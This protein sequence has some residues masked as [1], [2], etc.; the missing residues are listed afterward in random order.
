MPEWRRPNRVGATMNR[1]V[2]F[3]L[4]AALLM[5][6]LGWFFDRGAPAED[7]E[8]I[9]SHSAEEDRNESIDTGTEILAKAPEVDSSH[10][11]RTDIP[12]ADHDTLAQDF[13]TG[14]T[15]LLDLRIQGRTEEY[16]LAPPAADLELDVFYGV[17]SRDKFFSYEKLEHAKSVG[18]VVLDQQ[19]RANLK[20]NLPADEKEEGLLRAVLYLVPSSK[21]WQNTQA[22]VYIGAKTKSPLERKLVFQPGVT[23]RV[24]AIG[25]IQDRGERSSFWS[26][27]A[28][29]TDGVGTPLTGRFQTTS[30]DGSGPITATF[31]L[32]EKGT[33]RLSAAFPSGVGVIPEVKL[34]P[35]AP[36]EELTILIEG[37]GTISGKMT[38]PYGKPHNSV[39][40]VAIAE[41]FASGDIL[42][43]FESE[44]IKPLV[45]AFPPLTRS[46]TVQKDG[47]FRITGLAPGTYRLGYR[48]FTMN[49]NHYGWFSTPSITSGSEGVAVEL[50][51]TFLQLKFRN[52]EGALLEQ[53]PEELKIL[54]KKL[55]QREGGWALEIDS[56]ESEG[57]LI[58]FPLFQG[59]TYH[60]S[61]WSSNL[62]LTEKSLDGVFPPGIWEMEIPLNEVTSGRLEWTGPKKD[63]YYEVQSE[64]LNQSVYAW[65]DWWSYREKELAVDL[66]PGRYLLM[67]EGRTSTGSHGEVG[68]YRTPFGKQQQWVEIVADETT[69][70]HVDLPLSGWLS[71]DLQAI[72]QP[73]PKRLD[74]KEFPPLKGV[75]L[76]ADIFSQGQ[77]SFV[78]RDLTTNQRS[79]LSFQKWVG[80][81]VYSDSHILAPGKKERVLEVFTP[82]NYELEVRVPGFPIQHLP[83]TIEA[84]KWTTA[85][86]ILEGI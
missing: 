70:A 43:V 69:S 11:E 58:G 2:P 31:A 12:T 46:C 60:L 72:G 45:D 3:L 41:D 61:I 73:N 21:G 28:E 6:G 66:P 71:I 27:R 32:T 56:E 17:W 14:P 81:S 19:G 74:A 65:G 55:P 25:N 8:A 83:I 63:V 47:S 38:A 24:R 42:N 48:T 59:S 62:E 44:S 78:L 33:Y 84:K 49:G 1:T 53:A 13:F 76:K 10:V 40:V 20:I 22:T 4:L 15:K 79:A 16:Y 5:A 9:Q 50:P 68:N 57:G 37:F 80:G 52:A 29:R 77:A 23:I 51:T 67:A 18:K 86:V 26:L 36:P 30:E 34:D 64:S 39:Y 35:E 7:P 85:K 54:L 82:G 75:S